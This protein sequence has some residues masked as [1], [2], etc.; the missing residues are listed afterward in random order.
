MK[1]N[2]YYD[3]TLEWIEEITVSEKENLN[4]YKEFYSE[5]TIHFPIPKGIDPPPW[6]SEYQFRKPFVA[7]INNG[8]VWAKNMEVVSIMTPNRKLL[9][10]TT[11]FSL[12]HNFNPEEAPPF[13]YYNGT[14]A[15]L[16][17]AGANNYYHW[18]HDIL[19]RIHLLELSGIKVDKYLIPKLQLPFQIETIL[20]LAIPENKIIEIDSHNFHLKAKNL[21]ITSIPT[22]LGASTKW[23]CDFIRKSFSNNKSI[24]RKGLYD[25]L[26]ISRED[27]K[28][29]KVINERD[30][31][32]AL[33]VNGFKKVVLTPLSIEEQIDIFSSAKVIVSPYGAN[34]T[35]LIFCEPGTKVI[36]LFTSPP[37]KL[38]SDNNFMS[39]YFRIGHYM[40]LDFNFM[41]CRIARPSPNKPLFNNLF[42]DIKKLL[43]FLD[44]INQSTNLD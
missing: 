27:S 6:N 37:H 12:W 31:T 41:N 3:N 16:A 29:R 24:K 11:H 20:R 32:R 26:Y 40:G 13:A 34:L 4:F 23:A 9:R 35:N 39:E 14:V 44:K 38:F 10:D 36:Q 2:N 42:V 22:Y 21:V 30:V 43:R 7:M 25:K 15:V 33:S 19:S 17:W 18:L 1:M 5:E 28:W 8:S